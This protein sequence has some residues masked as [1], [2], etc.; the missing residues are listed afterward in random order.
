MKRTMLPLASAVLLACTATSV[1]AVDFFGYMRSGLGVKADG[2]GTKSSDNFDKQ[3]L[4]RLGNEYDTYSELG[5]GQ[6]VYDK[7]G[8][9][10]YV[11]GMWDLDS[12]GYRESEN[13]NDDSLNVGLKQMDIQAKGVLPFAPEATVWGGKRFYQRHDLHI[14]D[15]KYWNISGY[16]AGIEGWKMGQ[17]ALSVAWIRGDQGDLNIDYADIRYAGIKPWEGAWME[18]GIDYAITNDTDAQSGEQDGVY[19]DSDNGVMVT[20][21]ISQ[22]IPVG[23]NKTVFQ[24]ATKGLAQNVV[25]MGGGW[26]DVWHDT[27]DATGFRIINTGEITLAKNI[28]ISHVFTYGSAD[29]VTA[30]NDVDMYSLVA[31]PEYQWNENNKTM[32]EL[33]YYKSKTKWSGGDSKVGGEK[34]AL[35][36]AFTAGP[37]FFARPEIRFFVAYMK[38]TDDNE[39]VFNDG[40]LGQDDTVNFGAQVEA[41][42]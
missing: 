18:V 9:T 39:F 26:Y 12:Q 15:T 16:G 1:Q 41:W 33:G 13:T 36:H 19:F 4:G 8:K 14:I 17:G 7:D 5:L 10:F 38:R 22:T 30:T 21:E 29:D 37:G 32:I 2:G 3:Y 23:Y 27:D 40:D 6:Q 35:A 20:A 25:S 31:R 34:I 24:Y 28:I 11:E 42:W